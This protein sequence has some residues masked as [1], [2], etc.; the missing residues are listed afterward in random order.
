MLIREIDIMKFSV[1]IPAYKRSF[2]Q[3]CIDSVL[4]QTYTNFELII[5][6]DASPED[7]DSIV[8][9]Y[10][11]SRIRYYVNE[12]NCGAVNVVDNWNIC[13]SYAS[14]DYIICMG[15]DDKLRPNC[16]EEYYKIVK[17]YPNLSIYHARTEIIDE[18]SQVIK[19]QEERSQFES[20]YSMIWHRWNG[21]IQFIGDFLFKVS[22]LREHKGFF[23]IPFALCSDDISVAIAAK[24]FGIANINTAVFQYRINSQTISNNGNGKVLMEATVQIKKWY[25]EFLLEVPISDDD[26][27][28]WQLLNGNLEKRFCKFRYAIISK[29]LVKNTFSNF[30]YWLRLRNVYGLSYN[31]IV[32]S[33]FSG[34]YNRLIMYVFKDR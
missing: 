29:D 24:E 13:L 30:L 25:E 15:D 31:M 9:A 8:K 2:L 21:R 10:S 20:V 6:N 12:K 26:K 34:L 7:L 3:E 11:D 14:G 28:Y 33:F 16:L 22:I 32:K 1:T 27:L 19:L 17:L 18:Y 4:A 5:V 23:K